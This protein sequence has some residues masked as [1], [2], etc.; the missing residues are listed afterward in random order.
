MLRR[1]DV[2]AFRSRDAVEKVLDRGAAGELDQLTAQMFL[3]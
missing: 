2:A 1:V 3:E